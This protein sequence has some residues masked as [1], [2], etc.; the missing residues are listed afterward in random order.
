LVLTRKFLDTQIKMPMSCGPSPSFNP[1]R[2]A[3]LNQV[4]TFIAKAWFDH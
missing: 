3:I 4:S 2:L 1:N